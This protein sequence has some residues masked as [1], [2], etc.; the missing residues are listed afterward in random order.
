VKEA[1]ERWEGRYYGGEYGGGGRSGRGGRGGRVDQS[2][3]NISVDR[4]PET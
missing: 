1:L 4:C 2:F 3:F